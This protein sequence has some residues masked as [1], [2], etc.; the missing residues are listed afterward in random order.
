MSVFGESSSQSYV[1]TLFI[2]F[3]VVVCSLQHFNG[4]FACMIWF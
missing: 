1:K 3:V 4:S 2:V